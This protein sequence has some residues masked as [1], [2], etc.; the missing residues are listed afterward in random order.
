VI[1]IAD[2]VIRVSLHP[3]A[4]FISFLAL[5][6]YGTVALSWLDMDKVKN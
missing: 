5:A 4:L 6:G 3:N 2:E 1:V